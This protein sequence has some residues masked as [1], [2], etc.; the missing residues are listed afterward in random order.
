[1][2]QILPSVYTKYGPLSKLWSILYIIYWPTFL[3]TLNFL[4]LLLSAL[5]S[6]LVLSL[7]SQICRYSRCFIL[8]EKRDYNRLIKI[9]DDDHPAC[10][11]RL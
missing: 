1:M 10:D 2:S 9:R 6:T 11:G 4:V 3:D 7:Q 8:R 5:R